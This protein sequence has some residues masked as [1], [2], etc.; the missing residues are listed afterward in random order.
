MSGPFFGGAFFG[1]GFF[2]PLKAGGDDAP[3]KSPHRGWNKDEWLKRKVREDDIAAT[4]EAAYR[5]VMGTAPTAA[6]EEALNLI[7]QFAQPDT[8]PRAYPVLQIDWKRMAE[9]YERTRQLISLW[10]EEQERIDEEEVLML[11]S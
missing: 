2:G 3:R 11:L 5:G 7:T 8:Q 4:I 1:G 9:D 6:K 10:Q